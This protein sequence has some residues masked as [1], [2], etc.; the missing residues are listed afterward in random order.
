MCVFVCVGVC[1]L[2]VCKWA[3]CQLKA[4]GC[5]IPMPVDTGS[6]GGGGGGGC[7]NVN[8]LQF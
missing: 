8:G 1:Y 2:F 5:Y 7:H 6:E 3:T 4:L